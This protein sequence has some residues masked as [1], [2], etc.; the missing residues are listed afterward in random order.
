MKY[1]KQYVK[2][3]KKYAKYKQICINVAEYVKIC[4]N[5]K[6]NMQIFTF[7]KAHNRF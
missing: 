4:K 2:Y 5:A 3:A 6:N 7:F 1:A